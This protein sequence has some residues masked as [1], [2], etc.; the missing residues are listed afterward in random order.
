MCALCR[1]LLIFPLLCDEVTTVK[2]FWPPTKI[3]TF[4]RK[5]L[6]FWYKW[7]QNG[8]ELGENNILGR[9][10]GASVHYSDKKATT[11]GVPKRSP[12]QVLT[13]PYVV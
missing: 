4:Q 12:I 11:P 3:C 9:L 13:R 5:L 7:M 6:I 2:S 8:C 10:A 1:F